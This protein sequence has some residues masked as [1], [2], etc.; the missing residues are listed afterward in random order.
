MD[1]KE[2]D[3]IRK[4]VSQ[5]Y[6]SGRREFLERYGDFIVQAK[7]WRLAAIL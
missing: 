6:L 3:D 7:N 4:K 2:K 5:G 1:E